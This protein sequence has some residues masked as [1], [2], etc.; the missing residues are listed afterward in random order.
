MFVP[1]SLDDLPEA[2]EAVMYNH[3]LDFILPSFPNFLISSTPLANLYRLNVLFLLTPVPRTAIGH[4]LAST[5]MATTTM[6]TAARP[7][8]LRHAVVTDLMSHFSQPELHRHCNYVR[9]IT[10]FALDDVAIET[11]FAN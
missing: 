8:P 1:P 7:R 6:T 5:S 4:I 3:L 2:Q 10:Y 9:R 11:Y